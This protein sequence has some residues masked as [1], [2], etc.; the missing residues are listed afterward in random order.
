MIR[1]SRAETLTGCF[2][3]GLGIKLTSIM[4]KGKSGVVS[5]GTG[6]PCPPSVWTP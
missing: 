2:S 4:G 1:I 5:S 3:A 6:H